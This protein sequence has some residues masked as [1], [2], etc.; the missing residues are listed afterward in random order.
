[1]ASLAL[2]VR[3]LQFHSAVA[4]RDQAVWKIGT[5][6]G[7]DQSGE[8][9]RPVPSGLKSVRENCVVPTRLAHLFHFSRHFRAWLSLSRRYA[10]GVLVALAPSLAFSGSS[11][12]VSKT[13]SFWRAQTRRL[14]GRSS[15]LLPGLV[16][17]LSLEEAAFGAITSTLWLRDTRRLRGRICGLIFQP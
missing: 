11:H 8:H 14:K 15:T 16:S 9:R 13:Q 7:L 10:A 12:A 17:L 2:T 3:R 6:R 4:E 1:M 5:L